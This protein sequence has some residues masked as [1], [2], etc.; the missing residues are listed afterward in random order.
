MVKPL[1]AQ[2]V[3]ERLRSPEAQAELVLRAAAAK[4]RAIALVKSTRVDQDFL[5]KRV[6]F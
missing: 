2:K 6:T 1:D 5:T 3:I 4:E